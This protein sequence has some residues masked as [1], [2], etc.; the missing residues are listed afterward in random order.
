MKK[1]PFKS[2]FQ[3]EIVRNSSVLLSGNVLGQGIAFLVYPILTRLYSASDFGLFATFASVCTLL[4]TIGTGRYEES[5]IIAKNRKETAH[6]LGFSLKWLSFFSLA[7]WAI[8]ALFR[9][10]VLSLFKL[11]AIGSFWLYIP[12][13]V[14][15]TGLLYLLS[16]LATREKK[17]KIQAYSNVVR[18]S[19]NAASRLLLGFFAFTGI[20]FVLSNAIS[21]IASAFPYSSLTKFCKES[22]CGKWQDEKKAA[23]LYKDFPVFNLSR[24]F[25]SSFS[26]NLPALYLIGIFD[27]SKLGLFALAF[28]ASNTFIS[29]IVSSLFSTFFENIASYKRENKSVL[30]TLKTYWKSLCLYIL[31]GFIVAFLIAKPLFGFIFGTKWEESGLYFQYMLPWMF[32]M[33]ATSPL[34]SVFIVFKKQNKSL[35][36]EVIYLV[37]RW[38]A[39]FVGVYFMNFQLGILLFSMTGVL[40]SMVFLVWI[41]SIIRKYENS[42]TAIS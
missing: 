23:W 28:T 9:Q 37:L 33:L 31:P 42:I 32:L 5:L 10:P 39:L 40:I 6:L 11:E 35:W 14:F 12:I 20:G 38:L 16:N 27:A 22:L 34:Y 4:V 21:L 15:I 19:L 41:Y 13:S 17:F 30:P 36:M 1:W 18:S 24:N 8:L 2:L 26:T 3:S 29:L 25:L 7:L